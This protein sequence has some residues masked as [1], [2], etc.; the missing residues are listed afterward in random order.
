MGTEYRIIRIDTSLEGGLTSYNRYEVDS[1]GSTIT[2]SGLSVSTPIIGDGSQL[3]NLASNSSLVNTYVN[4][5]G[6]TMTGTLVSTSIEPSTDNQ[7]SLGTGVKRFRE[8]NTFS[9][10]TSVWEVGSNTRLTTD[11][12]QTLNLD[13]GQ[14][15]SGNTR[16]ITAN[17]SIIQDDILYGGTF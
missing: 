16:T 10:S 3:S 4:K 17:N 2:L 7:Y 15:S 1:T 14:D 6:D 12:V 9:G 13:L 5:T 8:L 11:T